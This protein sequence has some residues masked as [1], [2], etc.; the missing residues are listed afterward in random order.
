[1]YFFGETF[2][3]GV[4]IYI[5]IKFTEGKPYESEL[6]TYTAEESDKLNRFI[7]TVIMGNEARLR[8]LHLAD[9]KTKEGSQL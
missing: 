8:T 5:R 9:G 1:M 7:L 6:T 3:N 2:D 4:D